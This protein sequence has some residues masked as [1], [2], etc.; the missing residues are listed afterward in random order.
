MRRDHAA[1]LADQ[2]PKSSGFRSVF[3]RP[4]AEL[5]TTVFETSTPSM[6]NWFSY[7]KGQ[8]LIKG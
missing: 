8:V 7:G 2:H 4:E 6:I 1:G 5:I 3:L